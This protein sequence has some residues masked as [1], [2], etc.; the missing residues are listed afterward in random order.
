MNIKII[1]FWLLVMFTAIIIIMHF[2]SAIT[3]EERVKNNELIDEMFEDN[4]VVHPLADLEAQEAKKTSEGGVSIGRAIFVF[5]VA[6][7]VLF[8]F[9]I[10]IIKLANR[11]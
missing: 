1:I 11:D 5:I 2:A 9:F 10:L 6:C 7:I 8:L 4:P 3:D